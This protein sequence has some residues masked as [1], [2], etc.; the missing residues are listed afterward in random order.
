MTPPCGLLHAADITATEG[1]NAVRPFQKTTFK[2][3]A[4]F[5]LPICTEWVAAK[6]AMEDCEDP[7]PHIVNMVAH[8][9]DLH[10]QLTA[11]VGWYSMV[12]QV[13]AYHHVTGA[14]GGWGLRRHWCCPG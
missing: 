14:A 8:A 12:T 9:V 2:I 10:A 6:Q 7:T 1:P 11:E 4:D 5:G 13:G 3:S